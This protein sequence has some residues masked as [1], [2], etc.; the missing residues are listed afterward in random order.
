MAIHSFFSFSFYCV[1]QADT[2]S[3]KNQAVDHPPLD[4][5]TSNTSFF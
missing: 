2:Y 3:K 1:T 4:L 5:I